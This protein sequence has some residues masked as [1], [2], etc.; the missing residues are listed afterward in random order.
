LISLRNF[1]CTVLAKVALYYFLQLS[2]SATTLAF[3]GW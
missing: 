3:P 1:G 2:A